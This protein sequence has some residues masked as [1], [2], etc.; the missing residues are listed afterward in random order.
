MIESWLQSGEFG[1][2]SRRSAMFGA[3]AS[4]LQI[5]D[6][7]GAIIIHCEQFCGLVFL[8]DKHRQNSPFLLC[9]T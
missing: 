4:A 3:V 8:Q 9:G 6:R 5:V 7:Y 1:V 2:T